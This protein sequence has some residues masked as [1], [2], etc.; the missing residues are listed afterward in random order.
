MVANRSAGN[1]P[2]PRGPEAGV[3]EAR[4]VTT[5]PMGHE[6]T[7]SPQQRLAHTRES[8]N[9]A[10]RHH[11][12]HKRDQAGFLRGGGSTLFPEERDLLARHVGP[13]T[14]KRLLHPLCNSGQDSLSLAALGAS[15][16]GVD[17][18]DEAVGFART[19]SADSGLR[20][21]FVHSEVQAFLEG[22]AER[23][24][25]DVV[26]ASY[27]WWGWVEDLPRFFRGVAARMAAGARFVTVE[28]HPLVW[29]LSVDGRKAEPY[30]MPG[31]VFE[32]PVG[33]YVA[34]AA[35]ALSPSGHV[36]ELLPPNTVAA[37]SYQHTVADVVNAMLSVGLVLRAMHEWPHANGCRVVP[38]LVP[39][40][41]NRLGM[42]EGHPT[43]PLMLG[44][45]AQKPL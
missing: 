4:L 27:G 13:L 12:R 14:G 3:A 1:T 31:H 5:P 6:T 30:F 24:P 20:G 26:F 32:Q 9:T 33:D 22:D 7:T 39:L 17:L 28:F 35:G 2:G 40:P 21:T 8:W 10:T 37:H 25:F 42:P 23:T 36:E 34:D 16:V 43:M 29:S 41:G 38:G 45:V 19:L 15:V 18:S 44:L 11:N